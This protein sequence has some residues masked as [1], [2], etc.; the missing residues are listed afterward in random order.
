MA[1]PQNVE[2]VIAQIKMSDHQGIVTL[3]SQIYVQILNSLTMLP[4]P[5]KEALVALLQAGAAARS[6]PPSGPASPAPGSP[7]PRGG[8]E[9]AGAA[10]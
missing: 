5:Q 7:A 1:E 6:N 10:G 9:D 3:D 8:D 4:Q 2:D